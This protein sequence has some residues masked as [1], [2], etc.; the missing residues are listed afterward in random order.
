MPKKGLTNAI[1]DSIWDLIYLIV[2]TSHLKTTLDEFFCKFRVLTKDSL[3]YQN[4]RYPDKLTIEH[5][6][7]FQHNFKSYEQEG[8]GKGPKTMNKSTLLWNKSYEITVL[9]KIEIQH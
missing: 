3:E 9:P 8:G 5:I 2:S 1:K 6:S 4:I 7:F